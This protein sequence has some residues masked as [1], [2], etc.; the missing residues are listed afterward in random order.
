MDVDAERDTAVRTAHLASCSATRGERLDVLATVS[1][2]R[3]HQVSPDGIRSGAV[4]R[5]ESMM[6]RLASHGRD[7]HLSAGSGC[8]VAPELVAEAR[9]L[10]PHGR[11]YPKTTTASVREPW[12]TAVHLDDELG[13]HRALATVRDHA[14]SLAAGVGRRQSIRMRILDC[15]V[16]EE[17]RA[18]AYAT[19]RNE[20]VDYVTT[21]YEVRFLVEIVRDG[22]RLRLWVSRHS[23]RLRDLQTEEMLQEA[24]WRGSAMLDQRR[25][26]HS[27]RV[28][29]LT[30]RAAASLL[31]LLVVDWLD[32]IP[33]APSDCR[34]VD[35]PHASGGL[36]AR[37]FDEEGTPTGVAVLLDSDGTRNDITCRGSG[38]PDEPVALTGHAA[39]PSDRAMPDA[40]PTNVRIETTP[41]TEPDA[42]S[43]LAAYAVRGDGVQ[44]FRSGD[45]FTI[46]LDTA[47]INDGAPRQGV[48][49]YVLSATA[50]EVLRAVRASTPTRS[51]FP[52]RNCWTGGA[53]LKLDSSVLD[54]TPAES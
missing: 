24:G 54:L 12:D 20:S 14:E 17:V 51:Y 11:P 52:S 16:T 26:G 27:G 15:V 6:L 48:G 38:S 53:W 40:L 45:R 1:A 28:L 34:V 44:R 18:E 22:R 41:V 31:G 25:A 13:E 9:D 37:P 19:T 2:R 42:F 5:D 10:L 43:G 7:V 8:R 35:D 36:R 21:H 23:H 49:A 29:L 32:G 50:S 30:P 4:L 3:K 46:R 33:F 47:L 39:R